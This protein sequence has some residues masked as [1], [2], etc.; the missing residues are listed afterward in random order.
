MEVST[1]ML[2]Q[3]SK[4]TEQI[5]QRDINLSQTDE[6]FTVVRCDGCGLLYLNPRPAAE[7]IHAYYPSSILSLG[8]QFIEKPLTEC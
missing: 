8:G 4:S 6:F 3:A 1:C 7:E 5:K 2:C